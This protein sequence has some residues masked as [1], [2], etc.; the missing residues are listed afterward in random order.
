[1]I[2]NIRKYTGLMIVVFVLL[3]VSFLLL[4]TSSVQNIGGGGSVMRVDGR[5]YNEREFGRLGENG[6][7][8]LQELIRAGN[9]DLYQFLIAA[10]MDAANDGESAEK[11]FISRILLRAAADE[12]GL[13]PAE[14]DISAHIRSMQGFTG[15]DGEFDAQTYATFIERRIGRLG[16]NES[17]VRALVSDILVFNKLNTVLGSGLVPLRDAIARID[18][19]DNQRISGSVAHFALA[20]FEAALDPT[21]DEVRAY[22]EL[23]QDA[24]TTEPLRRFTYVYAKPDLPAEFSPEDEPLPTLTFEDL[25]LSEEERAERDA[26]YQAQKAA[27]R[28][29]E[30]RSKQFENDTK[31]DDFLFKLEQQQGAD[32]E[33]LAE[34]MGLEVKTTELFTQ[35][36]PPADLAAPLRQSARGETV[37]EQLFKVTIT[38][39]P[40][41]KIS[42]PLAVGEATWIIARL[43]EVVPS[44]VKTFEEAKEAA[45]AQFIREKA[46]EAMLDAADHAIGNIREALADGKSFPDSIE[47]AGLENVHAFEDVTQSHRPDPDHEPQSLFE[48]ARGVAPGHVADAIHEDDRVF[49]LFVEKRELLRGDDDDQRIEG[50]VAQTARAN[51]S[52]AFIAWMRARTQ[53]AD[54]QSLR[55]FR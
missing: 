7:Q 41:S 48:T 46:L 17:D 15:R 18:A 30:R 43:D 14:A 45:R 21:E 51:E 29:E 49:I 47:L 25:A 52:T 1:M 31:I 3:F 34:E 23:L 16:M 50:Q 38:V 6:S 53:A 39:D 8:L 13:R 2:E 5:T 40:F 22:W 42:N 32:F 35:A 54:V 24:F 55:R 11:L 37:V 19:F 9:W 4:D 33:A 26:R 28:A 44:R 27:E 20:P 10:T 36:E 12:F